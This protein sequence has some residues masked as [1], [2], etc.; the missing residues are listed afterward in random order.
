M[1]KQTKNGLISF[2]QAN[3][4][5]TMNTKADGR[6]IPVKKV[7][8]QLIRIRILDFFLTFKKPIFN[9]IQLYCL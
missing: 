4:K 6:Y 2:E 5:L 1:T 8:L 9:S 3:V 7:C